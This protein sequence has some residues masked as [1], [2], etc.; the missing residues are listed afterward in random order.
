MLP[1]LTKHLLILLYP[2]ELLLLFYYTTRGRKCI[3]FLYRKI[4]L[5]FM[6]SFILGIKGNAAAR[7]YSNEAALSLRS[8]RNGT[9][10]A[11]PLLAELLIKYQ[12]LPR[13]FFWNTS[14]PSLGYWLFYSIK[15]ESHDNSFSIFLPYL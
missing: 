13:G 11:V 9:K 2:T 15:S 14:L 1:C 7:K 5:F 12:R 3:L 4:L 8:R 6:V 10:F